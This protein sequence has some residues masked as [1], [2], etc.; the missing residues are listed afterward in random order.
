MK[1]ISR[2]QRYEVLETLGSGGTGTVYRVFDA[3]EGRELALKVLDSVDARSSASLGGAEFRLLA[4]QSHPHLVRVFDFG[5]DAGG[6]PYFTM[7]LCRG[8]DLVAWARHLAP[9]P[10]LGS[11]PLFHEVV[12]QIL[13]ALDF[14]HTRGLLHHDLKPSNVIVAL[15]DGKPRVKLI[16]F[17][18]AA[19]AG[20]A[21]GGPSGT[22]E[23]LAPERLEGR[24]GD[25]RSDLYALGVVLYELLTG[26]P[27]FRGATAAD[28][29]RGHLELPP[30]EPDRLP[31]P[32][33][34][35][36]LRLLDKSPDRRP[37]SAHDV[38][39]ELWPDDLTRQRFSGQCFS[40]QRFSGQCL[41]PDFAS[42]LVGRE[43]ALARLLRRAE[44]AGKLGAAPAGALVLEGPTGIGK[45][46]LLR[47]LE[48]EA[49]LRGLVVLKEAC[50]EDGEAPAGAAL[51]LLRRLAA[52]LEAQSP[53]FAAIREFLGATEAGPAEDAAGRQS[54]GDAARE[55]FLFRLTG[56]FLDGA[57][58]RPFALVVDDVH[59][60]D[61]LSR[62]ALAYLQRRLEGLDPR[63]AAIILAFR[64]DGAADLAV[65]TDLERSF[66]GAQRASSPL[67]R[68]P[69]GGLSSAD[70][71]ELLRRLLGSPDAF[72]D[73]LPER[74]V[75]E[76]AGNPFF[77]EEHLRLCVERGAVVR[78]GSGWRIDPRIDV[79]VPSSLHDAAAGR[80]ERLDRRT[81]EVLEWAAAWGAEFSAQEIRS[82]LASGAAAGELREAVDDVEAVLAASVLDQL[83]RREGGRLAFAHPTLERSL[84]EAIPLERR[85]SMHGA[86]A[87][88]LEAEG[89]LGDGHGV[90]AAARHLYLAGDAVR[91]RPLLVRAARRARLTGALREAAMDLSRALEVSSSA[92]ERFEVL[93][94]REE[95]LGLLGSRDAQL[96]DIRELQSLAPEAGGLESRCEV[97]LREALHLDAAGQKRRALERIEEAVALAR[98]RGALEARLLS[99]SAM[100]LLFLSEFEAARRSLERVLALAR[101]RKDAA[102]EAEASQLLG[103]RHYLAGSF[104]EA[105]SELGRALALR[106][107]LRDDPRAGAIESNIGLIQLDRGLLEAAE[108]RFQAA[109]KAFRRAG[110]RRG[111][112][113]SLINLG[114]VYTGMGRL[115]RAL[116][117]IGEAIEIRREVADRHGLG[118]D[119]GNLGAVWLR[120]G[121]FERAAP[122]LEEALAVA[123]E[124]ENRSSEAINLSRLGLLHL[125]RGEREAARSRIEESV[126]L[127]SQ[128]A[129]PAQ[130]LVALSAAARLESHAADPARALALADE[131]LATARRADMRS[132]VIECLGLRAEVL[133]ASGRIEEALDASRA[134]VAELEAF[135]GWYERSQEVWF[136]HHRVLENARQRGLAKEDES[137]AA[138]R[139]AYTLLREKADA[140]TDG[141]LREAFLENLPLHREID[142]RHGEMQRRIRG[143]AVRRERSF[144]QIARSIHA[145]L[146]LDPLLDRLLELAIETTRAEKGLILLRD[147]GGRLTIRAARGMAKESIDDAAEICRSVIDDVARGGEPVLATDASSD[148]RF[149]ARQ[150]VIHFQIRTLMCAPLKA[151]DEVLGA[152]YVDGRGT[153]SFSPEDLEYLV[154]FAQLAAVAVDNARLWG[155]LK[156]ENLYLRREVETRSR[157]ENLI[158]RSAAMEQL[159]HLIE[160]VARS[161]ASVLLSGETGTGKTVIAR[162]I[163]YASERRARPFVTVDCGAL[164]ENLLESELFGHKKGAFSGA[165]HD[166]VG[167]FE[168]A[169][170]GTL[171]LDEVSNTSPELQVKLLRVLQEGEIRRVGENQ[172]RSVDVRVIAATNVDLGRSVAEGKFREDLYYRLN[173]L[174]VVVPPLRSRREDVP[175]LAAHFL[176]SACEREGKEVQGFTEGAMR[177]LEEAPWRGNVRELENAVE[178]AVILCD[179][180]RIDRAFLVEILP[181]LEA[182]SLAI[183]PPAAA[184]APAGDTSAPARAAPIAAAAGD[185]AAAAALGTLDDFDRL[186]LEAERR[187]LVAVV[188]RAGGNLSAAS[189]IAGVR[190]RNTLISRMKK[191]GIGKA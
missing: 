31:A 73:E 62:E 154:S 1:L 188:E 22:V 85:R 58:E 152:V 127:A 66:S 130:R 167:L 55:A 51:R 148:D 76:T 135:A 111:E 184:P 123:R 41:H 115:E 159:S 147:D 59:W 169:E 146:D 15:D 21:S 95:L 6:R 134:A 7:E 2:S 92:A 98:G 124:T 52:E 68:L 165:I 72:A 125:E 158:G 24:P 19:A 109:L 63:P 47:E 30:P 136:T 140:F 176:K 155:R 80:I 5:I 18:L 28:V 145:I 180:D 118:A 44:S 69:L 61:S 107:E 177:L 138:L 64:N 23:Y 33:R 32:W 53:A 99:R 153:A 4:S 162:A 40:G 173:V 37:G 103:L 46:R 56:L 34:S 11:E 168:E 182:R 39:R 71:R 27:P 10:G 36:V 141:E 137:E 16:D 101:E 38:M 42:L 129:G 94:E 82:L 114:L 183:A 106:R 120:I 166:R 43:E 50:R 112:A 13:T 88:Q 122:L 9:V 49:R 174:H 100:L 119:A 170:G 157:F 105:L 178:K 77:V 97:I 160:K 70:I 102:L 86:I 108:E 84:H 179:T 139:R 191:H 131:A 116:D 113:M 54:G 128:A 60:A 79:P 121:R 187:Y 65:L 186:W 143:E 96:A 150:S 35:V 45:S 8:D 181:G 67:E 185:A 161:N 190:N 133:A 175:I 75:R 81:R 25:A 189:R 132:W 164:P 163:H 91:A 87:R 156:A 29:V 12:G 144:Y 26:Q 142:R 171:F 20:A 83:L 126:A 14:I 78:K 151:R 149:R 74:L 57:R 48:V 90:E 110:I 89:R 17:G 117:F 104:N 93:L 172:V 3:L